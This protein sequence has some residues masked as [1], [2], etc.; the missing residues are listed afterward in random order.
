MPSPLLSDHKAVLRSIFDDLG[1][2]ASYAP[3][4]DAEAETALDEVAVLFAQDTGLTSRGPGGLDQ[5]LAFAQAE[6][7]VIRVHADDIAAPAKDDEF[8]LDGVTWT[9]DQ[10]PA[11]WLEGAGWTCICSRDERVR[12]LD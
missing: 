3:D 5:E 11:P 7:A 6:Y 9:V 10:D 1:Q 4:G 8:E 2:T 12:G